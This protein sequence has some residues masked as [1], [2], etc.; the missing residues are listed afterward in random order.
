MEWKKKKK[1]GGGRREETEEEKE[2]KEVFCG[3]ITSSTANTL[4]LFYK[5]QCLLIHFRL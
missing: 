4:V 1:G 5:G 2:E 3:Q